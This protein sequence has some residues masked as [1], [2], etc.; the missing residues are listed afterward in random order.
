MNIERACETLLFYEPK[1]DNGLEDFIFS[2]CG[3][4]RA[5]NTKG[6]RKGT[7]AQKGL[8]GIC[9]EEFGVCKFL[10]S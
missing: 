6:R 7:Q 9:E 4:L 5:R 2:L 10:G 1:V 8:M 3:H